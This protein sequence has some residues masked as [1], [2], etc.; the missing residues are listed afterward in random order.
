MVDSHRYSYCFRISVLGSSGEILLACVEINSSMLP[1]RW[2]IKDYGYVMLTDTPCT[3]T[4]TTVAADTL[5]L[6]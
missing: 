2:G 4:A 3:T 6:A 5:I 1:S